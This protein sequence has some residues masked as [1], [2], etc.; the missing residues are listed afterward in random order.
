[1]E[2]RRTITGLPT[3]STKV[4][5]GV[6]ARLFA[7]SERDE[8]PND[9]TAEKER[10]AL[11]VAAENIPGVKRVNDHVAWIDAMSGM[12]FQPLG[13]TIELPRVL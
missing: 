6:S 9:G 7:G 2:A 3:P 10:Q 8:M 13:K 1:V 4:V 12:V 11:I 5:G